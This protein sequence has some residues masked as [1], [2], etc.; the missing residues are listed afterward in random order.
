MK[1]LF[2]LIFCFLFLTT[3]AYAFLLTGKLVNNNQHWNT[4]IY[5]QKMGHIDHFFAGSV[6]FIIDSSVVNAD[7]SFH[8]NNADLIKDNA[9][10]RI[11]MCKDADANGGEFTMGGLDEN[12]ILLILNK[13]SQ[14][15]LII[16]AQQFSGSINYVKT[17]KINSLINNINIIRSKENIFIDSLFKMR[18]LLNASLPDYEDS[19][20]VINFNLI[21][22]GFITGV[23]EHIK[24]FS[25]TVS[26]PLVS[27]IATCFLP[28]DTFAT[29]Y[30]KMKNRYLTQIP[31]SIYT[32]Q[33]NSNLNGESTYLSVGSV[34]PNF[35]LQDRFGKTFS[36]KQKLGKYVLIDFWASWC[37]P[38]RVEN[39]KYI[40]YVYDKYRLNG[41]TVVSV[42]LDL[43]KKNWLNAITVDSIGNWI[44]VSDFKGQSSQVI[45]D[46]R[47]KSLP[48]NYLI[49][50]KG[51]IIAQDLRG[52]E[53]IK[54]IYNL[55]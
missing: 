42:S 13:N 33:F 8:F 40:K 35:M 16:D 27:L 17:D 49:D 11:V 29:F 44:H 19:L 39:K 47:I 10:Y 28:S 24:T 45:E 1:L 41:F 52:N 7:G 54:F 51:V 15:D 2:I 34:A 46:Y 22:S 9:I 53:L 37:T 55:Y 12:F 23:Y 6:Q 31:E 20:A 3:P 38:C 48:Y 21:N 36:L 5:L 18:K 14:L 25:D 32:L 50:P 4:K 30:S 43:N 26:D